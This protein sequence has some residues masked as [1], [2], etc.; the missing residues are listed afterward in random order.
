MPLPCLTLK[1]DLAKRLLALRLYPVFPLLGR[2][3]L[4]DTTLPSGA[5]PSV[6][7]PIFVPADTRADLCFYAIYRDEALFGPD[8]NEF[9]HSRWDTI[10]PDSWVFIPFGRGPRSCIGKEKAMLEASYVLVKIARRFER[11]ES[12]DAKDYQAEMKLT[13]RNGNGCKVALLEK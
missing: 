6:D 13:C 11:I 1:E 7:S 12:R 9:N 3:S 4:I 5:G 10:K 2:I 8:A